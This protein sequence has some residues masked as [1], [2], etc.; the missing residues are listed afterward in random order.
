MKKSSIAGLAFVVVTM[1]AVVLVT[2]PVTGQV[3]KG[4]TRPLLTKQLM[5][6]VTGPNCGALGKGLKA[7]PADDEAWGALAQSAA[8]LN[9]VSYILMADGRCPD[10]DW[11][12]AATTLREQS[13]ELLNC[14]DAQDAEGSQAA[15]GAMTK[16]CGA[17]HSKHK[18]QK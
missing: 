9:E 1:M 5:G 7:A 3:K 10:G 8:L 17:C 13:Q 18:E 6:G 15:F 14:I 2:M 16:A 4:T 12:N 11:A